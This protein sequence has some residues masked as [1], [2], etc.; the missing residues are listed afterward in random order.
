MSHLRLSLINRLSQTESTLCL[1]RLVAMFPK[2]LFS[3]YLG[4]MC[5]KHALLLYM[6]F[7]DRSVL[8]TYCID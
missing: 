7:G 5:E 4:P 8:Q 1:Q 2:D 3:E 6:F